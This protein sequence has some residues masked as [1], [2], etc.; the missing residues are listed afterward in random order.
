M[1]LSVILLT[2]LNGP[3]G[4]FLI[5]Q[6]LSFLSTVLVWRS[7][8][9]ARPLLFA[10]VPLLVWLL[11][12]LLSFSRASEQFADASSAVTQGILAIGIGL[13]LLHGFV[14][15]LSLYGE[16]LRKRG[17]REL[18]LFLTIAAAIGIAVALFMPVDFVN[19]SI[20][21]NDLRNP[22]DPDFVP[23][24][25]YGNGLEGG[26]LRSDQFP[27]QQEGEDGNSGDSQTGEGDADGDSGR[28]PRL[29]GIPA[30]QWDSRG[31]PGAGDS[32]GQEPSDGEGGEPREGE[33]QGEGEN[34]QYAVMV[35]VS[36]QDPVYAADGYFG[37]FD[38]YRG[39]RLSRDNRLNEL[40]Y[41]RIIETWENPAPSIDTGRTPVDVFFLST[42]S[43]RYLPYQPLAVQPTILN[44][45]YHPFAFSY[46]SRSAI[47]QT[48]EDQWRTIIGL[49]D[50]DR[51]NLSSYLEVELR[52]ELRDDLLTYFNSVVNDEQ[53]YYEKLEAILE[54][55]S[56]FQYNIGFTDDVS[57]DRIVDFLFTSRDGDCT[58]FSN[59]T[60]ILARLAGIPSRVVTGYLASSGLQTP[61][62]RQ[63]LMALQEAIEP[64]QQYSLDEM[65]LVTTAHRHSW[66]QVYMPG[67][68]WID[69]ETTA[70]ALPPAAGFD[71]N[72][73]DIVIPII[74]PQDVK[75]RAFIFPW[76]L[77]LQ[78][79]LVLLVAGVVGAYTF[80]FGR[81]LFLRSLSKGESV[82]ALRALYTLLLMRLAVEGY[83]IKSTA[84]TSMEY[85]ESHP[86]LGSFSELY[87]RLRY[88]ERLE[89]AER[90]N[91]LDSI[92]DEYRNVVGSA[93]RK[94]LQGTLRRIFSLKDLR[95]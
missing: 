19:H 45:V 50:S 52:D 17:G 32:G 73:M 6:A 55:Y 93:R 64:L 95:Y 62:H 82:R 23:L 47:S 31:R 91:D 81:L 8:G 43:N 24:D 66:V 34:R 29:Q 61:Q 28:T 75:N 36:T 9:I 10:E 42:E 37:D 53:T 7:R 54:S 71:P 4:L 27:D 51:E 21:L 39:L 25:D 67:Y 88:R 94:G 2:G 69:I 60:A 44:K 80:R 3:I 89:G 20:S 22:P 12:K 72:S 76:L 59:S 13:I 78:S 46:A 1:A 77:A 63:G 40:T 56:T 18:A 14:L 65:F 30:E 87:T 16:G 85:A 83:R 57:V 38:P 79:L 48:T 35:V 58:E 74:D 5:V 49:N 68:G 84:E 15:Y 11:V 41:L 92:R 86:E 26:N 90:E 70:T 33:G